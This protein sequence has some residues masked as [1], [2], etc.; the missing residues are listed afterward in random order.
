[1]VN[2]HLYRGKVWIDL[3]HPT[4]EEIKGIMNEYDIDPIVAHELT[5][6]TQNLK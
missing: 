4:H 1:M 5:S 3:D 2:K 6:P